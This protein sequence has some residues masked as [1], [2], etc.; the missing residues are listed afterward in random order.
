MFP[1]RFLS[2]AFLSLLL[3]LAAAG[4]PAFVPVPG[5]AAGGGTLQFQKSAVT[6]AEYVEFLNQGGGPRHFD[7]RMHILEKNGVYRPEPGFADF[8]VTYVS[9]YDALAYAAKF[10]MRLPDRE[11]WLKALREDASPLGTVLQEDEVC[12][13]GASVT[14]EPAGSLG[15]RGMRGG[16]WE[17]TTGVVAIDD[18]TRTDSLMVVKGGSWRYGSSG[19]SRAGRLLLPPGLRRADVGFRCVR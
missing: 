15:L 6:N 12:L 14:D 16:I 2:S 10:Q 4:D 7:S 1:S 11:E 3:S 9:Y 5:A 18:T 19:A 17:W 13:G 8:P